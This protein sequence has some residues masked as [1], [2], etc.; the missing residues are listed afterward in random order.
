MRLTLHY[1]D[2]DIPEGVKEDDLTAAF[3]DEDREEWKLVPDE[4]VVEVDRDANTITVET[5]HASFWAV[6]DRTSLA[7]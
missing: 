3:F 2:E 5:D 7:T 6:M 1:R 4:D